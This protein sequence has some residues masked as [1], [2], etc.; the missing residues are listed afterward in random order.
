MILHSK[1]PSANATPLHVCL[2]NKAPEDKVVAED[3]RCKPER[4]FLARTPLPTPGGKVQKDT[5]TCAG[6]KAWRQVVH[7][8]DSAL[9]SGTSHHD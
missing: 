2:A 9:V 1:H 3:L 5:G 4:Y 6:A 8:V 7:V